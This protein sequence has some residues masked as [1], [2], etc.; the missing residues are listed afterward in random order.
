MLH[1]LSFG[2]GV[3]NGIPGEFASDLIA[4][5]RRWFGALEVSSC[6]LG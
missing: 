4:S 2:D 1:D 3:K 5:L 6:F